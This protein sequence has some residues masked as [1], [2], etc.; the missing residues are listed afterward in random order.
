MSSYFGEDISKFLNSS[1]SP[2]LK[3]DFLTSSFNYLINNGLYNQNSLQNLN[4]SQ[5][6]FETMNV[7]NYKLYTSLVKT[8]I[9]NSIPI[10]KGY[11]Y[12]SI[13]SIYTDFD[14]DMYIDNI[15]QNIYYIYNNIYN[16][17]INYNH[18]FNLYKGLS[19]LYNDNSQEY[20]NYLLQYDPE[21]KPF[22]YIHNCEPFNLEYDFDNI[23]VFPFIYEY[24]FI[25]KAYEN[26]SN[27]N[28]KLL[29]LIFGNNTYSKASIKNYF[30]QYIENNKIDIINKIINYF[31][32][33]IFSLGNTSNIFIDRIR[34]NLLSTMDELVTEFK[35]S[36]EI[37]EILNGITSTITNDINL[38]LYS[39]STLK[40]LHENLYNQNDDYFT[41]T[42]NFSYFV[43]DEMNIKKQ[44]LDWMVENTEYLNSLELLS[45][46][47][48]ISPLFFLNSFYSSHITIVDTLINNITNLY[49]INEYLSKINITAQNILNISNF[50]SNNKIIFNEDAVKYASIIHFKKLISKFINSDIFMNWAMKTFYPKFIKSVNSRYPII[51]DSYKHIDILKLVLNIIFVN[52]IISNNFMPT[53]VN[54]M[55]ID[56]ET[57]IDLT[58]YDTT[59]I[60][61]DFLQ[62]I[63]SIFTDDKYFQDIISNFFRSSI[64]SKYLD[65]ILESYSIKI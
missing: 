55:I 59:S 14:I 3:L 54:N 46:K 24:I 22:N 62:N 35:N 57:G 52:D 65:G 23:I 32:K 61:A 58:E 41:F 15:N 39:Y 2:S 29:N 40:Y 12:I 44:I 4:I 13:Q 7:S 43:Q 36:P 60:N 48:K 9:V 50:I 8:E 18:D 47:Y 19:F 21:F 27:I 16:I 10:R 64:V 30:E 53:Y 25:L 28:S 26:C 38:Q 56:F 17:Y 49:N 33:D 11:N 31:C 42:N 1:Q 5:D 6:I 45:C 63:N 51:I 34:D 20:I 37:D